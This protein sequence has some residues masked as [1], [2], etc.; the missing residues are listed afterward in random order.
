M[1]AMKTYLSTY[2]PLL[3]VL[4]MLCIC[5]GPSAKSIAV[6]I[7]IISMLISTQYYPDMR[8]IFSHPF[9][10]VLIALCAFAI[11]SCTWSIASTG[12]ELSMLE[13]Y[14]KLI[15]IPLFAAGFSQKKI[16]YYGIH[17]YLLGMC[18]TCFFSLYYLHSHPGIG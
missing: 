12:Q 18:I 3:L 5:L 14:C 10:W 4:V 16:R 1:R 17:A 7:A 8:F 9:V 15:Y 13:K 6:S 2:Q 11:A